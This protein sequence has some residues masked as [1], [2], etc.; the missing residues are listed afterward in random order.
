MT[1][2]KY[3]TRACDRCGTEA[4]LLVGREGWDGWWEARMTRM[5]NR[6]DDMPIPARADLCP[7]CAEAMAVWWRVA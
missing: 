6:G 2:R 5:T 7:N 3:E 4:E 1:L